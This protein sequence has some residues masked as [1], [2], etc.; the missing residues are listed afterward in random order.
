[1][2][3]D[4]VVKEVPKQQQLFMFMDANACTGRRERGGVG[5]KINKSFGAYDRNAPTTTTQN[6][7]CLLLTTMTS[8]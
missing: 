1:M 4:I 7:C 2:I 8:H 6:Y 3:L 5:C